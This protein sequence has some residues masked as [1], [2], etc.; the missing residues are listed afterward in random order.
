MKDRGIDKI[1]IF[2]ILVHCL[3]RIKLIKTVK[4]TI[5]LFEDWNSSAV[6]TFLNHNPIRQFSYGFPCIYIKI[7]KIKCSYLRRTLCGVG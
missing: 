6:K 2:K 4:C 1:L 5:L 3:Y 7:K